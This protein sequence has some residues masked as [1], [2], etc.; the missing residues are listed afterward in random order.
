M[1]EKL[2]DISTDH[3][4]TINKLKDEDRYAIE[5]YAAIHGTIAALRKFKK[6]HLH[7]RL[8][9]S[10]VRTMR[11]RYRR[12]VKSSPT[13]MTITLLKRGRPVMLGS[14][15]EQ[16]KGFLLILRSKGG[17]VNTVVAVVVAKALIAK[18]SD[19]SLKILDLDNLPWTKSLFV[20]MGFVKR[21]CTTIRPEIPEAAR[22]EA[23]L[24]FH[25]EIVS[26]VEKYFIPVSLVINIDQASLKYAPVSSRTMGAKNSNHLHVVEFTYKQA[27]IGTFGIT[28]SA[29]VLLIQLI[30]DGK[31]VQSFPKFKFSETFSMSANL[32]QFSHTEESL[33]FLEEII[34]PY[35]KDEQE[36]LK[37]EPSQP[38][39]MMLDVFS[40]QMTTPVTDKPK[41]NHIKYV[42]VPANMTNLFQPL[43]LIVNKS[44]KAFMK[45]NFTEWYSLQVTK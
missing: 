6:S 16:V 38:A 26:M 34:I 24:I 45:R 9:E 36:K 13:T 43:D 27:I 18:S 21:A 29:N 10:S 42:P 1:K 28:L 44:V 2:S 33:K 12:I 15:A 32:K 3:H 7:Y 17:E 35:V 31:T 11:D 39:L 30:Y 40:G 25:H 41:E 8:T 4:G 23:V 20:R 37:L 5:K 14:L 19:E 22:K